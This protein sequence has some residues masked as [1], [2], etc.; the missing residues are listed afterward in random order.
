M[1]A[2]RVL[3]AV[4]EDVVVLVV[5]VIVVVVLVVAPTSHCNRYMHMS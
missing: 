5:E 2:G 3:V 4:A 1:V